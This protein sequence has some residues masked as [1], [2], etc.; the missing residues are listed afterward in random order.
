MDRE[1]KQE[2]KKKKRKK[3]GALQN[4][5]HASISWSSR[6]LYPT[7][8]QFYRKRFHI[9]LRSSMAAL[10]L[11]MHFAAFGDTLVCIQLFYSHC[12][13]ESILVPQ[14]NTG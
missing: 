2:K 14:L 10:Y 6:F 8:S 13:A 11:N 9:L 3:T 4:P 7:R 12:R 1:G 5:G